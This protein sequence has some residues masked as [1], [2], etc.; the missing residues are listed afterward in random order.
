MYIVGTIF[1]SATREGALFE[2]LCLLHKKTKATN[3]IFSSSIS[4]AFIQANI[5]FSMTTG[6]TSDVDLTQ[7]IENDFGTLEQQCLLGFL[8]RSHVEL[9]DDATKRSCINYFKQVAEGKPEK[10]LIKIDVDYFIAHGHAK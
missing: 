6:F 1:A 3:P 10:Y 7:A 5:P 4:E 2:P 9:F 8:T